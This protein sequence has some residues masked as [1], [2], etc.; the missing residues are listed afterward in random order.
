M[1]ENWLENLELNLPKFL[2]KL[3]K[4]KFTYQAVVEGST[5]EGKNLNLGFSCYAL[6]I[7]FITNLWDSL[8]L[9]TQK[10]W[11]SFINSFQTDNELF[12]DNSFVDPKYLEYYSKFT[13]SKFLKN[14]SKK[15]INKFTNQN[16][17]LDD[18]KLS[19]FIRAET[20][21]AISTLH[22]VNEK[23]YKKYSMFPKTKDEIFDYL[24]N[25]DWSK[26]W[27]A[28]AQFAAL[29]VFVS[30]QSSSIYEKDK[31]TNIL[32][33]FILSITQ[34]ETGTFYKGN[35]PSDV[36]VINGAMK[37]ITGLDWIGV[38]IPYPEKLLKTFLHI[39]VNDEGCD[40]VDIVYVVYMCQKSLD[41]R[42]DDLKLFC[43]KILDKIEKHYFIN[44]GG[45]SYFINKS[46]THYY[47]VK[48]SNG[49]NEPDLHGTLLLVWAISMI[50]QI[51]D[52]PIKNW[53]ILKP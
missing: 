16:Y 5:H 34:K 11:I 49:N 36:E 15:L 13:I 37:V 17:L 12:P 27:N 9:Q 40:I 28:G 45:F 2:S 30:T 19:N 48:I 26:P 44:K 47:G 22:E 8:E 6:K 32:E 46:Q 52:T 1:N 43:E 25:L 51:I 41:Y 23:N 4:Q 10:E 42:E 35:K 3:N 39:D 53:K 50:S 38:R 21:Q 14:F 18:V 29:C 7:Y 20:K 24:N 31:L 33:E